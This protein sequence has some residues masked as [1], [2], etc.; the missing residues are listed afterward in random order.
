M[1]GGSDRKGGVRRE[2]AP[3]GRGRAMN[4]I[5][6]SGTARKG[7]GD[8]QAEVGLRM[9]NRGRRLEGEEKEEGHKWGG[10]R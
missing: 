3:R 10:C 2:R 9:G 6:D 8:S 1:R 7:R 5:W 4:S